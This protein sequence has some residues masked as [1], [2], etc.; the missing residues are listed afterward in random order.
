[1]GVKD[2]SESSHIDET[3]TVAITGAAGYIGSRVF[4][5]LQTVHP[6]WNYIAL[7]NQYLGQVRA[8]GGTEIAHVDIR[9]RHRLEKELDGA[10][11]VIHLAAISG[12][13]DCEAN[14]DLAY[15]VNVA[16]TNNVAWFCRKTGAALAFPFSM[17]V[18]GDPERFPITVDLPR[19]PMNWYGQTKLLGERAIETFADGVFPAHLFLKSNLYGEH[20]IDGTAVSK[21]T[22]INFFVDR[23]TSG[24]P[25]TVYEP[26]MQSRNFIHVKDVAEVYIKSTERLLEALDD[27]TTG[28]KTYE[29]ASD[30]DPSVMEV[31]EAVAQFAQEEIGVNPVVKLVENPR[32][33]ETV[34]EEFAVDTSRTRKELGWEPTHT[35]EESIRTLLRRHG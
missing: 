33:G 26:G 16:G 24:E 4:N 21:S 22:V 12:V 25:L 18:L 8:V 13:D 10:D 7:D 23:I 28:V 27:G 31:A 17:A 1:M 20:I 6:G 19:D 2:S 35:I 32:Q 14:P 29:V 34:V 3:P 11:V 15:E 30:D 9:N 5:R